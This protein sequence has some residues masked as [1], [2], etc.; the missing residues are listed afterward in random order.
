MDEVNRGVSI[1][2]SVRQFVRA[3]IERVYAAYVDPAVL[4]R[5]MGIRR[6]IDPTG[7]LDQAGTSF[8]EVVFG[9]YRPRSHVLAAERPTLH[10]LSGRGAFGAGY[11]WTTRFAADDDGTNVILDAEVLLP[12]NLA[13]RLIRRFLSAAGVERGMQRRLASFASLV[14]A[15]G[16]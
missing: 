3:P 9:P 13:G 11:R 10:V 7:S 16:G 12:R 14:E 1:R 15:R 5:W 2:A 6:I 4:S 8:T